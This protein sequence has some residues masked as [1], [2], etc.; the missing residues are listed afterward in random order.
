[1][2]AEHTENPDNVGCHMT[3]IPG[4]GLV[5]NGFLFQRNSKTDNQLVNAGQTTCCE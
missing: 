1:M 4:G 2:Q 5:H 3:E